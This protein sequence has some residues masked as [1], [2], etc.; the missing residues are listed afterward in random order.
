MTEQEKLNKIVVIAGA[1]KH[2]ASMNPAGN[3]A[4]IKRFAKAVMALAEYPPP[5]W[6]PEIER[7]IDEVADEAA[8]INAGGRT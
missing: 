7:D 2:L 5:S 8:R 1:I 4:Q 3:A 6:G